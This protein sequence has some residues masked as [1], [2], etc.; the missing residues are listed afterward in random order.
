MARAATGKAGERGFVLWLVGAIVAAVVLFALF[1]PREDTNDP[2]PTSY[3][4]SSAGVKAAYLLLPELGYGADRWTAPPSDLGRLDAARTTLVIT[5]PT[6][7]FKDLDQVQAS[8]KTFMERGGRVIATGRE[9]ATLLPGGLTS[10]PAGVMGGLCL[11][12]GEGAGALGR[13]Q[14]VKM[15]EPVRW[16]AEGPLY[17][18]TQRCGK[19]AV[20]VEY[21]VGRGEAVWWSSPRPMTNLGL[22][23]DPS[24]ALL[25]ASVGPASSR[26]VLFDEWLHAEHETVG[27]T[28]AGL[29]WWPLTWQ[30]VAV[31][32]LLMLSFGRRNGPLRMPATLPRT[33]PL[34]FA[35]SMGRLYEKAGATAAATG[36]AES[37]LLRFLHESCGLTRETIRGG[38]ADIGEALRGRFGGDWNALETDLRYAQSAAQNAAEGADGGKLGAKRRAEAGPGARKGP[39]ETG[40]GHCDGSC[41]KDRWA[42][43]NWVEQVLVWARRASCSSRAGHRLAV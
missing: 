17:R 39:A 12:E 15:A 43:M 38:P 1:G 4:A 8:L 13:P 35:E 30:C 37:R 42:W 5:E 26:T 2:E 40:C 31:A 23:D 22:R 18:V 19:D 11:T 7:P 3:N 33:S 28:L 29:P 21:P 34:E 36:A 20:V 6:L 10:G 41:T 27:S 9:G 14:E 32:V 25:L 24:L 16:S